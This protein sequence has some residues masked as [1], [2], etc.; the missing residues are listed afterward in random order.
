V[1]KFVLEYSNRKGYKMARK[2]LKA[3]EIVVM[4]QERETQMP[5]GLDVTQVCQNSG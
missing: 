5:K 1:P 4:L 2:N 3:E